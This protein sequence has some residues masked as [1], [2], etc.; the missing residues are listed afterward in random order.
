M[1]LLGTSSH[2]LAKNLESIY[3][4]S[5]LKE[6]TVK[7][8]KGSRR[9]WFGLPSTP[10]A[11]LQSKTPREKRKDP[12]RDPPLDNKAP[13]LE[14]PVAET[15]EETPVGLSVEGTVL[16]ADPVLETLVGLADGGGTGTTVPV[17]VPGTHDPGL[18]RVLPVGGRA[19]P[20]KFPGV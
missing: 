11:P 4:I 13:F 5:V 9:V 12:K 1:T 19:P 7:R 3:G 2:Q 10:E 20:G 15:V 18:A 6:E 14:D 16:T 17:S 8:M